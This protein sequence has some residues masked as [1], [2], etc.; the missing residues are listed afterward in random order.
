M[1]RLHAMTTF[2]EIARRGSLTAAAA[3][4]GTSLPTVVRVLASLEEELGVRLFHRTTRRITLTEEARAYLEDCK[5]ILAAVQEAEAAVGRRRSEPAGLITITA[6][7][8][9]GEMHVAPLVTAFLA[10]HAKVEARL[11]LLDRVVDLLEEGID[12]AVRIAAPRDST[13]VARHVGDIRQVVCASPLLI[14][15][16][17]RPAQPA[18]LT[19]LPC[20]RF[21][22]MSVGATWTFGEG[23]SAVEISVKNA[24]LSC[25]H[26]GASLDA[27]IAGLGY[28]RFFS[29]QVAPAVRAG[30]LEIV[31]A[32]FEPEPTP[33]SLIFPPHWQ[34]PGRVR[35]FVDF[36]ARGLREALA[37]EALAPP[38]GAAAGASAP[39]G[40]K[41]AR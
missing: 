14:A 7:V 27:C 19:S 37:R 30:T 25:N 6:P 3:A 9:F 18:D 13:L 15:R 2:V 29:Y 39:R 41:R 40:R 32:D 26:A 38:P 24:Q 20:V 22:G 36:L 11:L 17:G 4:L 8:R 23:A 33:L 5:R 28:G 34:P 1:D 10:Q 21:L 12:V 35:A 16:S 31:L